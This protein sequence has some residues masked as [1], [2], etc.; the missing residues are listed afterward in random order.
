MPPPSL[1]GLTLESVEV[2]PFNI[3]ICTVLQ[4]VQVVAMELCQIQ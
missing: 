1:V 3:K 2:L 4:V